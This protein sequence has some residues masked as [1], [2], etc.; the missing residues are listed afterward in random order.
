MG[1]RKLTLSIDE[2]LLKEV[3]SIFT[4]KGVSISRV[5]EEFLESM[6]ASKW[7]E[8]LANALGYESLTPLDPF[9]IPVNRPDGVDAAKVVRELRDGRLYL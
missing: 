8:E 3:K 5:V 7:L 6:M 1:R 4:R 2:D 9:K